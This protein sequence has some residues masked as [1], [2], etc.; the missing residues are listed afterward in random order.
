M[1]ANFE[2]TQTQIVFNTA[3]KIIENFSEFISTFFPNL[4]TIVNGV[5]QMHSLINNYLNGGLGL[6]LNLKQ[7]VFNSKARN[8]RISSFWFI[9]LYNELIMMIIFT[10][11]DPEKI[12]AA[13]LGYMAFRYVDFGGGF[14]FYYLNN[15]NTINDFVIYEVPS[16]IK[17]PQNISDYP[18]FSINNYI[19]SSAINFLQSLKIT[20]PTEEDINNW[21][22]LMRAN[23]TQITNYIRLI[24]IGPFLRLYN[25]GSKIMPEEPFAK[26]LLTAYNDI[27]QN[28]KDNNPYFHG[29]YLDVINH[30]QLIEK[31]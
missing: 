4:N 17:D 28:V 11:N 29:N 12:I 6:G 5:P 25:D 24:M 10:L 13:G 7:I 3:E 16:K 26:D 8:F 19:K 23:K 20:N 27:S 21:K 1:P 31:S 30:I 9:Y 2:N 15:Y 22:S 18:S 14:N